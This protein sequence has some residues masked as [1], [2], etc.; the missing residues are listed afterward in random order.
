MN[1]INHGRRILD[2][3]MCEVDKK[4]PLLITA[5]LSLIL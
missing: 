4:E 3:I 1:G 2:E 5:V